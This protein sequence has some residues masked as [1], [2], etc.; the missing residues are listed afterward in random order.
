MGVQKLL[1]S[2][3]RLSLGA[4]I[5]YIGALKYLHLWSK[6][7]PQANALFELTIGPQND[8]FSEVFLRGFSGLQFL[9]GFLIVINQCKTAAQLFFMSLVAFLSTTYNPYIVGY[10]YE[11]LTLAVNEF[12]LIG[13]CF[14]LYGY[15]NANE[16]PKKCPFD[17]KAQAK[18]GV[19]KEKLKK[20]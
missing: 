20:E 12:S 9:A 8:L 4:L 13:L 1:G 11:Q 19:G 16:E 5:M 6:S 17:H 2:L 7:L 18:E 14:L 15:A 3:V 10:G